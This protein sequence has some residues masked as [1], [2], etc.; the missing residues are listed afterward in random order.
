MKIVLDFDDT[1]FN[2]GKLMLNF[3]T[4]ITGKVGD[5]VYPDFIDFTETFGG[6]NLILLS[7]SYSCLNSYQK[8]KI[9]CAG[10]S[11]FFREIIITSKCKSEEFRI[12]SERYKGEKVF[13]IDD[14]AAQIDRVKAKFPDI[15]AIR[16]KRPQGKHIHRESKLADYVVGDL[17]EAKDVICKFQFN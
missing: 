8:A 5:F 4:F 10:I 7:F 2:T 1:I 6:K 15:T 13:F 16:M 14:K 11:S 17:Y 3:H 9:E 12:L